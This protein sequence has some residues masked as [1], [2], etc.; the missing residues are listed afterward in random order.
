MRRVLWGSLAALALSAGAA[1][2]ADV[3]S[4]KLAGYFVVQT[5]TV[6]GDFN[7]CERGQSVS[8][9]NG[10][11]FVCAGTGYTHARNPAAV[12]LQN[13]RGSGYKLLV[14]GAAYDGTVG[15]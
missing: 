1:V 7:G 11:V 14:N 4:L 15:R 6:K 8:L 2:A 3:D 12:L 10:M 9:A 5:T 13:S